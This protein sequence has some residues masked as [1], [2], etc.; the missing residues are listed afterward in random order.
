[1]LRNKASENNFSSK[2]LFTKQQLKLPRNSTTLNYLGAIDKAIKL[3]F[4]TILIRAFRDWPN[5][6]H[7]IASPCFHAVRIVSKFIGDF[8]IYKKSILLN[9]LSNTLHILLH[10]ETQITIFYLLLFA[11]SRFHLLHQSLSFVVTRCTTHCHSLY[12]HSLSLVV[13]RLSFYKRSFFHRILTSCAKSN[14][15]VAVGMTPNCSA[16]YELTFRV[17]F[18]LLNNLF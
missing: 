18:C 8:P 4:F 17:S 13:T 12:H 9:I 7:S 3:S 1:M 14:T 5:G 16:R 10:S 6:F 2:L 15:R 11:F